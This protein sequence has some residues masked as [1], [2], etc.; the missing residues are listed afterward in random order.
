M[1]NVFRVENQLHEVVREF[2]DAP[3]SP[4]LGLCGRRRDNRC[5][6]MWFIEPYSDALVNRPQQ[7][8]LL[9]EL[10][11]LLASGDLRD[12]E[13]EAVDRVREAVVEVYEIGGYLFIRGE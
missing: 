3:G 2:R 13:R 6:V 7:Q 11:E 12:V 4:F 5:G 1:A 9:A 8:V 10:D